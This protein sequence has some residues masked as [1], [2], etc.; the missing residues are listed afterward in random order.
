[1][2]ILWVVWTRWNDNNTTQYSSIMGKIGKYNINNDLA[3][4]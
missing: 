1:M 3:K 2:G 4:S